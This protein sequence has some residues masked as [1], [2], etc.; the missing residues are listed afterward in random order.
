MEKRYQHIT[1]EP[2]AEE[3]VVIQA[4]IARPSVQSSCTSDGCLPDA[5]EPYSEEDIATR[6]DLHSDGDGA[7]ADADDAPAAR[8]PRTEREPSTGYRATT[9]AD[10]ERQP[11]P[12][13]QK[14]IIGVALIVLVGAVLYFLLFMG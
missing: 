4:G 3:D 11:M 14:A 5:S 1:V 12:R 2:H 6:V 10:L 7:D 9:L 8:T 13:M